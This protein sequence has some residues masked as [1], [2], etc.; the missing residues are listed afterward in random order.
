MFK[1][2]MIRL[3][4]MAFAIA[5]CLTATVS[6]TEKEKYLIIVEDQYAND[7]NLAKF[8]EYRNQ[9][10]D[11][12]MLTFSEV[13]Q[14]TTAIHNKMKEL[15]N[16]DGLKYALLIGNS[17]RSGIPYFTGSYN[18]FHNYALMDSDAYW[19]IYVGCFFVSSAT[20][21]KNIIHKT[22]H[23]EQ[24]IEEYPKVTTQFTSYTSRPHI[25]QQCLKIKQ[26]YWEP[27]V[28]EPS[29]MI[30]PYSGGNSLQYV[31]DLKNQINGNGSSIIAYQAHGME[32]GWVNGGSY[33]SRAN[34]I[35]VNDVKMFTNNE[36]YP[37][38]MSFACV[39][40]SFQL[41]GGFGETWTTAEGGACAF[42]GSSKN[43]SYYQKGL[44]AAIASAY[45]DDQY[46]TIGEIFGEAKRF[47][48][49]SSSYYQNL[50]DAGS[51]VL[52]DEQMYNLFGDP[53]MHV[54][55]KPVAII[56]SNVTTAVNNG[57]TCNSIHKGSVEFSIA[58][59]GTYSASIVS[60]NGK[61]IDKVVV[62][63]SFA[64]GANNFSFNE[65]KLSEGMYL[66]SI[67]GMDQTATKKFTVLR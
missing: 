67:E 19:D 57:L 53:G 35:D 27:S 1:P 42:I 15:Y 49:D 62:N 47:M 40:G 12:T 6:A 56:K 20:D 59:A 50:L 43:S 18:T 10:Y 38:V 7:T 31:Q 41:N 17:G 61:I 48:R 54:K 44:N 26:T 29:W 16:G 9:I 64:T 25:E 58:K 11:V 46:K 34:S 63:R 33:Y 65:S 8:V 66:L 39:T 60:L 37:V 13:G 22:M 28:Y 30:P 23:T 36:V 3:A 51:F 45:C 32:D 5:F 55:T 4:L 2:V 14:T 21:L 24:N 52:A